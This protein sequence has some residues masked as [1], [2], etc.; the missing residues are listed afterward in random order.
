MGVLIRS[1]GKFSPLSCSLSDKFMQLESSIGGHEDTQIFDHERLSP[2]GQPLTC[3]YLLVND[4]ILETNL[5]KCSS[6]N[7]SVVFAISNCKTYSK[8]HEASSFK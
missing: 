7:F 5:T 8:I 1:H 2:V 6:M 3:D 4:N